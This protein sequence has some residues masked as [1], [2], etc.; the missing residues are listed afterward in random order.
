M[1]ERVPKKPVGVGRVCRA[2]GEPVAPDLTWSVYRAWWTA[3]L[4]V[5]SGTSPESQIGPLRLVVSIRTPSATK[6]QVLCA[7]SVP[8][9]PPETAPPPMRLAS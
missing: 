9:P 5:Q 1:D 3:G 7:V 4:S 6:R 8:L 2:A